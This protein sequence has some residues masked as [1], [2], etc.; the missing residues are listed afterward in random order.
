MEIHGKIYMNYSH[1]NNFYSISKISGIESNYLGLKINKYSNNKIK[2]IEHIA[3]PMSLIPIDRKNVYK[4]VI[5]RWNLNM[6][7]WYIYEI[8][9]Y[10]SDTSN[11]SKNVIYE[12]LTIKL[13]EYIKQTQ[14]ID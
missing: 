3:K 14:N 7:G 12:Y 11:E 10:P 8:H 9:F 13:I 1:K 5:K 4:Q 2:I 6:K